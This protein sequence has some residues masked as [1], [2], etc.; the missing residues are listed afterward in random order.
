MKQAPEWLLF[1]GLALTLA[2]CGS[3]GS[4]K[5]RADGGTDATVDDATAGATLLACLDDLGE[6]VDT[7][8][9]LFRSA[10]ESVHLAFASAAPADYC[11]GDEFCACN[12]GSCGSYELLAFGIER[13]GAVTC[14]RDAAAL[15]YEGGHHSW[16]DVAKATHGAER[17]IVRMMF[18]FE[19][20]SYTDTLEIE[21]TATDEP[22][23][24]PI[25]LVS[26]DCYA[27]PAGVNAGCC[28]RCQTRTRSD[29]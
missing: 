14:V 18:G 23:G 20:N 15:T 7:R 28:E 6:R 27:I 8:V 17:F 1:T 24:D 12:G 22:T 4:K 5:Q 29:D 16:G 2:A 19:T 13:D 11:V 25:P 26:E 3:T 10:D 21:S 9:Q